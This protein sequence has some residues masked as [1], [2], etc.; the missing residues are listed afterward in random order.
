[1]SAGG[2]RAGKKRCVRVSRRS[3]AIKMWVMVPD[4]RILPALYGE[5]GLYFD[6]G[7]QIPEDGSWHLS[8]RDEPGVT[9]IT[10]GVS[11]GQIFD[12]FITPEGYLRG[13]ES[14]GSERTC[15]GDW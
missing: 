11:K 7:S 15:C 10:L 5:R 12:F 1:M 9:V 13:F 4:G 8:P 2:A 6:P 14:A 3:V